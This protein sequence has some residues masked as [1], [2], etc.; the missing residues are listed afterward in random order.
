MPVLHKP[1][2]YS[3]LTNEENFILDSELRSLLRNTHTKPKKL[4][5]L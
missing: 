4:G 5:I 1:K 3:G 2:R